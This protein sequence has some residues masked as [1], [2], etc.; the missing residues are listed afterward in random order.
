MSLNQNNTPSVNLEMFHVKQNENIREIEEKMR[1][2]FTTEG[3]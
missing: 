2:T 1:M 3:Y